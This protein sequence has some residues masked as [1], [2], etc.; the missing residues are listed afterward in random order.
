MKVFAHLTPGLQNASLDF[1]PDTLMPT[2]HL[3]VGIPG[4]S[5]ALATASRLGLPPEIIQEAREMLSEGTQKLETLLADLMS[6]KQRIESLRSDLGKKNT[7]V[8]RRNSELENERQQLKTEERKIIQEARDRVV[9]EAAD[10]QREI[11]Q[12]AAELRREKSK[13]RIEQAKKALATV[14]EQLKHEAW[15]PTT[16]VV[17]EGIA[18]DGIINA[19]DTV[20]LKEANLQAKVLSIFED[21]QQVEVQAGQTRLR[22]NLSSVEKI[23]PSDSTVGA[24]QEF[25]LARKMVSE[26]RVSLELDLRGKRA[27]EVEWILDGYLDDASLANLSEVRI[28]HGIGTGT[29]RML[30]RDFLASHSLVKSFRPGGKGEGGDGATVVKL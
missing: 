4:G 13:E 16:G 25:A 12:A 9:Y 26:R 29:L 21:T 24:R 8:E 1:D 19:G 14:Q 20:W 23:M 6:E 28:V 11:R 22:L 2:Y 15:Q 10:L 3:T 17:D 30:V 27:D 18:E 5:N 7:E